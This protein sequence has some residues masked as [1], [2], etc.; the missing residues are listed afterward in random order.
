MPINSIPSSAPSQSAPPPP[1]GPPV[2]PPKFAVETRPGLDDDL[3]LALAIA[4]LQK[5]R[6]SRRNLLLRHLMAMFHSPAA[7]CAV[8]AKYVQPYLTDAEVAELCNKSVRQ[9][10]R[11]SEYEA[12]R[13]DRDNA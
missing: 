7:Q 12:F 3:V 4:E 5:L 1:A 2:K 11:Y 6:R 9:L 8:A 13:P 10:R